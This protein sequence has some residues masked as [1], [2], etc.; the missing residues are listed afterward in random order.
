MDSFSAF[1]DVV[2]SSLGILQG[3]QGMAPN[4]RKGDAYIHGHTVYSVYILL[5]HMH[6]FF[7]INVEGLPFPF[8]CLDQSMG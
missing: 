8:E 7:L 6:L 1:E 3:C 5:Q 4:R 2:G